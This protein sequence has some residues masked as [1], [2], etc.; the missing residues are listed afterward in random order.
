MT[1]RD[2]FK[3]IMI[4]KKLLS[5]IEDIK[6]YLEEPPKKI[7]EVLHEIETCA[8]IIHGLSMKFSDNPEIQLC[9]PKVF[10]IAWGKMDE[11]VNEND[12]K[13]F[14]KEMAEIFKDS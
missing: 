12:A 10:E 13:H 5:S 7:N 4:C 1:D 6:S 2:S 11:A 8:A 3:V 9:V 14:V